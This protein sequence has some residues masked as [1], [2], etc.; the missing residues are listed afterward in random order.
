MLDVPSLFCAGVG[1]LR[2]SS[3][4]HVSE[5]LTSAVSD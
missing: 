2:P 3:E 4:V 5:V 1:D